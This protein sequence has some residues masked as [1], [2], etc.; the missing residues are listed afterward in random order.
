MNVGGRIT[1]SLIVCDFGDRA[2]E[3]GSHFRNEFFF[4]VKVVSEVRPKGTIQ[5]VLVAGAVDELM[6]QGAVIVR[7][8]YES[9]AGGH[10][11]GIG[12]RPIVGAVFRFV[13]Q[14]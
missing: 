1:L 3:C 9:G 7:G 8:I 14:L 5:P 11:Y 12:A 10:V 4:A 6:K 2:Q 13:R